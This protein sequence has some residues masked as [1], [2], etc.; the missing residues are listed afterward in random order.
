MLLRFPVA[1]V[2]TG[3]FVSGVAA[4]LGSAAH[5]Q[6]VQPPAIASPN[7][8]QIELPRPNPEDAGP[9]QVRVD[10]AAALAA[11]PCPFE[12]YDLQAS[13]AAIRFTGPAGAALPAEIA[14]LLADIAARPPVGT[15]PLRIV[16]DIRDRAST[17][18]RR[19]GY[20]A[21]VQIPP[22]RLEGGEL[23]LE[24]VTARIVDVRVR[25]A[26][27]PYGAAIEQRIARLKALTPLN[28]RDAERVLLLAGDIPGLDVRLGLRPAGTAP[29]EVIGDLTV[30]YRPFS[31][32][33][34]VQNYGSR[35]L[36][37]ETAYV[38][39]EYYGL[40]GA[41]DV[42]YVGASS[43]LDFDEQQVVQGGHIMGLGSGGA[44]IGLSG[45]YAWSKPDIGALDLRSQSL[46]AGLELRAPIDVSVKRRFYVA[47][48]L[49]LIEQRTRV[50]DNNSARGSVGLNRD[51]L[52][53]AYVRLD[54]TY[55]TRDAA[56]IETFSLAGALELRKGL[57]I[58]NATEINEV[59]PVSGYTPSRRNGDPKATVIRGRLETV[60]GLGPIFSL[61][62]Q[63]RG[64][65]SNNPLLNF[66]E[67]AIGN[68]TIG[69]GYDPGA[70]SAD[71]AVGLRGEVRAKVID[72]PARV[73][74]FGFYDSVWLWNLGAAEVEN[75]RRLGSFGG[76]ARAFVPGIAFVEAI[77][78]RPT[79][80]ALLLPNARRAPDRML[81][82]VT[83]QFPAG[84][85]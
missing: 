49:E 9:P 63:G 15:Q 48:G 83:F 66:E 81:V 46:I 31:I 60:I 69:R 53:V 71:R 20:V 35:Q 27:G 50:Y 44:T 34:N 61:Y 84:A 51:K 6:A 28:E 2:T 4:G 54:G 70:N 47:G 41:S 45:T 11:A 52:R 26:V 18:L 13:I 10:S 62:G 57:D 68:L 43:T 23:R 76:G 21:S 1:P 32:L 64:Q 24:V 40:T 78:A 3:L 39:G 59:N 33:A 37:R 25:G 22:Q 72:V 80:R 67:Y 30:A 16:C 56:G 85:R 7:R 12:R 17:A 55:R 5:A 73:E 77:Y 82:S 74:L 38:R 19:A 14:P 79:N 58:F 75:D 36:G 42:T 8:D 65:W 29:G